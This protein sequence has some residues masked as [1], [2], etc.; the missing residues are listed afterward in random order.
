MKISGVR[1]R[2]Q[3]FV[4]TNQRRDDDPLGGGCGARGEAVYRALKLA[5]D[6]RAAW[7]SVWIAQTSCL[8]VCP[9]S[10]CTIT[11]APTGALL[12]EAEPDDADA[13]LDAMLGANSA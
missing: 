1:R 13:I 12:D 4:C 6:R 2:L 5:I 11:V 9:K 8:G 7:K 3:L 10:G